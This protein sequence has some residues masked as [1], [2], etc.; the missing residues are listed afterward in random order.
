MYPRWTY[1][2]QLLCSQYF[3]V[4]SGLVVLSIFPWTFYIYA[5]L[6]HGIYVPNMA[7]QHMVWAHPKTVSF[8][9]TPIATA[10]AITTTYFFTKCVRF[11]MQ[12]YLTPKTKLESRAFIGWSAVANKHPIIHQRSRWTIIAMLSAGL[13]ATLTTGFTAVFTPQLLLINKPLPP[14]QELDM[15]SSAFLGNYTTI[16]VSCLVT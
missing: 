9:V 4:C 12:K 13:L 10:F 3:G 1:L 8:I 14:F 6:N 2:S 15:N 7:S 11:A 5:F 16:A